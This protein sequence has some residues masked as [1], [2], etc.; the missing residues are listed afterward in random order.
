MNQLQNERNLR[1][2]EMAPKLT[3]LDSLPLID[4][5]V[6]YGQVGLGGSLGYENQ[7]VRVQGRGYPHAISLHAP[8]RALF[9]IDGGFQRFESRVAINGDVDRGKSSAD[10]T[11]R[12]DGRLVAAAFGVGSGEAPRLLTA[13][14]ASAHIL[15]LSVGTPQRDFCHSVW[16][17]PR[18]V[19]AER[20]ESPPLPTDCL[21]LC[22]VVV[23]PA[24]PV[25]QRCI[26]T[27]A[28]ADFQPM[29]DDMLGSL[30]ANGGCA[31]ALRVVLA[32][33]DP[34]PLAA[35]TAKYGAL[36]IPC[37]PRTSVGISIKSVLYS[38]ARFIDAAQ[39]LCLDADILVLGD[40]NPIF[41]ALDAC[42]E[43]AILVCREQNSVSFRD[44]DDVFRRLY[45][46]E[47]AE[48]AALL[49]GIAHYPFVVN[50]GVFAGSRAALLSLDGQLSAMHALRAWMD[51]C[52]GFMRSQMLFNA[53]IA[54]SNC[55]VELDPVYNLQLNRR[56]VKVEKAGGRFHV[57][58]EGKPIRVLH[59]NG[60]GRNKLAEMRG[61]Y[62]R[63]PDPLE[64]PAHP[65]FYAA[66]L[67]AL[68]SWIGTHGLRAMAWSFYGTVGV[69]SA[70]VADTA[71]PLLALLHYLVR[72]NGCIRVLET[73]TA[74][75]VSSACLGS[76]VAHREGAKVVTLDPWES[77]E[78]IELWACMP[79]PIRACL[80]A[81]VTG[82]LEGMAEAI[83][84]GENYH[85]ALLDS[86]HTAEHV[87][88]EF[89]LARQLVSPG[90]L[91]L[92][93]D[94]RCSEGT[95]EGAL[96]RIQS[97]GYG[98]VRLWTAD[99]GCAEDARL[100]LAVIENRRRG[101]SD[102]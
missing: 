46:G 35:T 10:F 44:L 8:A 12:A 40:L 54:K 13:D 73:G 51:A 42:S 69:H 31:D 57:A 74:R 36:L 70:R 2:T 83:E 37:R 18:L 32:I 28:S 17:D 53:A 30:A 89:E 33:G 38:M 67:S 91:I 50:D 93:H 86:L 84:R 79:E 94:A 22:D 23:A 56:D 26:A 21:E 96:S 16:L 34:A 15:E 90:G 76:A 6:D 25:A 60:D 45:R 11:V 59:F 19:R 71:M 101:G 97:A 48:S 39:F 14:V 7:K 63:V 55:G 87:W 1:W 5:R 88:A 98:V 82:S 3:Q 102:V 65:D 27:V 4:S 49:D 43:N 64:G 100:G 85:A 75:G 47:A 61:C 72:S 77:E 81:R 29:L 58:W 95:V 9:Q 62:A 41:A 80:E 68:R 24:L 20:G 52:P 66:F 92:V 99:D 78:R